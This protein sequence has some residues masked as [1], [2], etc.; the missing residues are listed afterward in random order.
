MKEEKKIIINNKEIKLNEN[1]LKDIKDLK[2]INT[3]Y[4][5]N[6]K[7]MFSGCKSLIDIKPLEKWNVSNCNNFSGM[8]RGCSSLTDIKPLE[9][10]NVSNKKYFVDMLK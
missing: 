4:C 7:G 5:N 10:W 3:K 6:F 1:L 9:K 8:F 2:Y